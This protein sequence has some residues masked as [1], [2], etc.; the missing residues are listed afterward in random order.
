MKQTAGGR[1]RMFANN[2]PEVVVL[3]ALAEKEGIGNAS[4]CGG[5][6]W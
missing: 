3:D 1:T 5:A 6:R 4:G 2:L